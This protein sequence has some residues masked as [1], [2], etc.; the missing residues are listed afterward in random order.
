M[1]LP[2]CTAKSHRL[3]EFAVFY[4]DLTIFPRGRGKPLPYGD[5][6]SGI[7]ATGKSFSDLWRIPF[8]YIKYD[9][10]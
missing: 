1:F 8:G 5:N 3:Y 6:R 7:K 9:F 10:T 2:Q 4:T